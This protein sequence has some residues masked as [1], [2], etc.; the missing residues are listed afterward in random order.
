MKIDF[1]SE[2]NREQYQAVTHASGPLLILAGAGSG[3]TRAL[4]YRAAYLVSQQHLSPEHILLLT[5][6]NKAAEEMQTR[7]RRLVS[8][9]LPFA[10][11]FHSFCAKFLRREGKHLGLSPG[12]LIYDDTDQLDLVKQIVKDLDL[13][14]KQYK[15]RI[16]LSQIS[17]AK[18][19]LL[20]PQAYADLAHGPF[21]QTVS[22]V[23]SIY[24]HTLKQSDAVDFDDLLL[25]TL[26]ILQQIPHLTASYQQRYQHIL[27]DE[28]QDTNKAQYLIA[29]TLALKHRQLTAVGDA[30]QSI[31]RWRGADYR[32]L[33]YLQSDFP[34]LT[35]IKLEQNYRSTQT[36]LDAA[37]AVICHNTSHPIL[38]LWTKQNKGTL[39]KLFQAE[40]EKQEADY[41]ISTY[42]H[43]PPQ[44]SSAI[45]YRTN[46]Q[47]RAFEEACIRSGIPYLL[48]GGT[49]FYDRKE[50]K[51]VLSYLKLI[52]NPQ[53]PVSLARAQ[54]LGLR[55]LAAF[56]SGIKKLDST[57]TA[58]TE[59]FD[60]ALQAASY[61]DRYNPEDEA[62][63][64]RLENVQELRAV[65]TQF[66]LLSDFL[67]NVALVENN[68]LAQDKSGKP[69][70]FTLDQTH[71]PLVLMTIHASKGLEFDQVFLAGLEEGLFPHSRSLLEPQELE[72]ER[73]L[74]YVALTRARTHLTLSYAQNRLY[75]GGHLN[76]VV[77]RFVAEIPSHLLTT[78]NTSLAYSLTSSSSRPHTTISDDLLDKFLNDE[79]DIDSLFD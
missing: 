50:I 23:Y 61:L 68:T 77:S 14:I 8:Q 4:T 66:E 75:F 27:V 18:T 12:F 55:R 46:A 24:Q 60:Q 65:S 10:G 54:K 44:S 71:P 79:I 5:F 42:R 67:Q 51:D 26:K 31:Y 58:A 73:R 57:T 17:S 1:K 48:V 33:D 72:E 28:Y 47:S 15:P 74:C 7:L 41:I 2:L 9:T 39:L 34:D 40:D 25:H 43:A 53:D 70:S 16:L 3:K 22:Q 45:L 37:T 29:Q 52:V 56:F 30:S 19:E 6:T 78:A 21:Q 11:T 20:S 35:T 38:A 32:N 69:Q 76:G 62:D 36:I 63:I 49:K 59:I 13:D 64:T